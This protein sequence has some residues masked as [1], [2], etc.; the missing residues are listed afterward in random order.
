MK[1]KLKSRKENEGKTWKGNDRDPNKA[2]LNH[3]Q[4]QAQKMAE[5][6]G[7]KQGENYIKDTLKEWPHLIKG[8]L[9]KFGK[10]KA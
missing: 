8:E 3:I 4:Q 6:L 7:E 2:T 5:L 9:E 10:R 1:N